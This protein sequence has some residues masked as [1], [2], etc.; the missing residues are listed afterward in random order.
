KLSE[1]LDAT[2]QEFDG[3][4]DELVEAL[5]PL[6][7]E[8]RAGRQVDDTGLDPVTEAPLFGV[9]KLAVSPSADLNRATKERL[10]QLTVELV[11]HLRQELAIVG[12]WEKTSAVQQLRSHV[13]TTLDDTDLLPYDELE[14][15]TDRILDLAKSNRAKL[16]S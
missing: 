2:L 11:A 14:Y 1:R 12:F 10:R 4:W 8:I 3:R 5:A 13:F 15:V 16:V 7:A 6:V 9:L